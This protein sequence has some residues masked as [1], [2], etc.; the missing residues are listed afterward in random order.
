MKLHGHTAVSS[1]LSLPRRLSA[2]AASAML[3]SAP[4]LA[5][6]IHGQV[7]GAAAPIAGSS[8]TLWAAGPSGPTELAQTQGGAD[9]GCRHG[10]GSTKAA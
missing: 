5:A 10:G 2:L 4:V 1:S 9:R 3:A 7:L 8:V 6:E